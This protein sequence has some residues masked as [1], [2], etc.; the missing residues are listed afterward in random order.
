MLLLSQAL[1]SCRLSWL[2]LYWRLLQQRQLF[3]NVFELLLALHGVL[4]EAHKRLANHVLHA[5]Q[6]AVVSFTESL[7]QLGEWIEI[8]RV[9]SLN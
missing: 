9:R 7:R 8:R 1:L 4:I 6:S 2:S 5:Q 3:K